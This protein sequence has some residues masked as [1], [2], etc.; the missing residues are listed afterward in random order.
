M[1]EPKVFNKYLVSLTKIASVYCFFFIVLK[2]IALFRGA[3]MIPNIILTVPFIIL[4]ILTAYTILY[5][6]YSWTITIIAIAVII[7]VRY[8][9]VG[10]VYFLQDKY[11]N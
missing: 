2:S 7:A 4:G 5:K 6:K 10:W 8:Y 1:E 11:G 9:E 3:W